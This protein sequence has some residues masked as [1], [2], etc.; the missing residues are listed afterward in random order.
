[1][2]MEKKKLSKLSLRKEV[3]S[4]LDK[5]EL[6]NAQGGWTTT[7]GDCSHLL[8]CCT[9]IVCD[10]SECNDTATVNTYC[11]TNYWG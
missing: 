11:T 6:K 3:I 1:M 7:I 4:S 9:I 2:L 10:G 5:N 8:C